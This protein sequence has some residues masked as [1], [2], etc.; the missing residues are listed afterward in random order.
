MEGSDEDDHEPTGREFNP[1]WKVAEKVIAH[2]VL[3][4]K[5]LQRPVVM[6]LVKW[7]ELE[8]EHCTW[9]KKSDLVAR[10]LNPL[11]ERFLAIN[12]CSLRDGMA[13]AQSEGPSASRHTGMKLL[14]E[15]PMFLGRS[16]FNYQLEVCG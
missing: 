6:L 12:S 4:N 3:K 9:E 8:H 13:L 2:Q 7:S 15:S 1:E 5:A 10:E 11:I 16:L 14:S